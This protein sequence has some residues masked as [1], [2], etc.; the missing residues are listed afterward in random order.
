MKV[1]L[2]R[3]NNIFNNHK[4]IFTI[5]VSV[6]ISHGR[7]LLITRRFCQG[8][9]GIVFLLH[10]LTPYSLGL[11]ILAVR[12]MTTDIKWFKIGVEQKIPLTPVYLY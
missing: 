5:K 11:G 6:V 10:F 12:K 3:V 4:K 8:L 7:H 1:L 2:M 9:F